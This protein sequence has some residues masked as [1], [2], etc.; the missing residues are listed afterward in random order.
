MADAQ[1]RTA[2]HLAAKCSGVD[3]RAD[4][5]GGEEIH[6]VV[7]A[8]FDVDF[9]LGEAGNVGKRDAVAWVVV[10]GCRHQALA[11]Q[12]RHGRLRQFVDIGG[13]LVA[14]VDATQLNRVFRGLRQSHAGATAL[15]EN[16]LVGD[17]VIRGSAS[18]TLRRDFL[19]LLRRVHPRRM[20]RARHGVD[21]LAAAAV[22]G[23]RQILRRVSPG[24]LALVPR[25]AYQLG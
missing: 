1:R 12:C 25:H 10:L 15:A 13:R 9:N 8:G 3:Y 7:L 4:I 18:K 14:I 23:P 19:E 16:T 11:R 6:D 22:A 21:G 24:D 17:L 20:R 5:G 2:E